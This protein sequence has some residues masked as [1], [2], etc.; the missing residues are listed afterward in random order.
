MT[1][2]I[3]YKVFISF[4]LVIK[5]LSNQRIG[6]KLKRITLHVLSISLCHK[7][8]CHLKNPFILKFLQLIAFAIK[9][10]SKILSLSV[11]FYFFLATVL[12]FISLSNYIN[13]IRISLLISF[14]FTC[15]H[16]QAA[17][18]KVIIKSQWLSYKS[19]HEMYYRNM[20][21]GDYMFPITIKVLNNKCYFII[22]Q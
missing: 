8:T 2:L 1:T 5:Q 3:S 13:S 16:L 9:I 15:K 11:N 10:T 20:E 21:F 12:R 14:I 6:K 7:W 19:L 22:S 4:T 18:A 17:S